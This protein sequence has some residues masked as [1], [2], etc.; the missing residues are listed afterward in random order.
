[1][2]ETTAATVDQLV[3]REEHRAADS[4]A[5]FGFWVYIMT[6]CVLFAALFATYAVLHNNTFGGPSGHDIF[7]PSYV[8]LETMALLTSS[9]TCGLA[10]L[11]MNRR[12]KKQTLM[13]FFVTFLLGLL[14]LGLELHEFSHLATTGASWRRS[15][16]LSSYFTLVGAHGMH[17]TVGLLWMAVM[18]FRVWK[19]DLTRN[20]IRRLTLLSM[21]WHFLDIV[22]IFI[23][24][25]VYMMGVA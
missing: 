5:V 21:F 7:K 2:S 17:I 25:I 1:M 8:L 22:W 11:A 23:F 20:N 10:T 24:T 4:K 14:F 19:Q 3:L 16:F 9:F 13:W 6:D 15:A 12:D 18:M